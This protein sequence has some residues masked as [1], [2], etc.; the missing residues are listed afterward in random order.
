[1]PTRNWNNA[2]CVTA[3]LLFIIFIMLN[4]VEH[5]IGQMRAQISD[6]MKVQI[7]GWSGKKLTELVRLDQ[8][9]DVVPYKCLRMTEFHGGIS[10]DQYKIRVQNW[11]R[12]LACS[13]CGG[14]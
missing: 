6:Q 5:R 2:I 13:T 9:T 1:M 8:F 10:F 11:S 7:S 4:T 12:R 14:G 3:I